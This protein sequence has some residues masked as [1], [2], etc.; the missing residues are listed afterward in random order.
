MAASQPRIRYRRC[1]PC[2]AT[3]RYLSDVAICD[4]QDQW[5]AAP[6]S[7]AGDLLVDLPHTPSALVECEP[8]VDSAAGGLAHQA[9]PRRIAGDLG[10][11]VAERNVVP[12]RSGD[13]RVRRKLR[14]HADF[15]A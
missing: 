3:A 12:S 14:D 2:D 5:R 10:D 6:P 15:G 9:P 13:R 4:T 1:R 8:I 7:V 11:R